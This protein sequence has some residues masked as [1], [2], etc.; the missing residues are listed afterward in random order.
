MFRE[1]NNIQFSPEHNISPISDPVMPFPRK[2]GNAT[3]EIIWETAIHWVD[4][5]QSKII[6]ASSRFFFYS[7]FSAEDCCQTAKVLAFEVL[8]LLTETG[9]IHLFVPFFFQRFNR[10]LTDLSKGPSIDYNVSI[11]MADSISTRV[12]YI[13]FL[14]GFTWPSNLTKEIANIAF[15][16]MTQRQRWDWITYLFSYRGLST[17]SA[18]RRGKRKRNRRT[19]YKNLQSGIQ[20]V[21]KAAA[22]GDLK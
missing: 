22:S 14:P 8:S 4:S 19:F 3:T 13:S 16:H 10:H 17:T 1:L 7:S 9:D 11:D 18:I 12:E 15:P 21:L 20:R 2:T 5:N 6:A